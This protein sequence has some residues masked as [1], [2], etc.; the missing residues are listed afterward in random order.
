MAAAIA[1]ATIA[2]AGI[3]EA[4]DIGAVDTIEAVA[5]VPIQ[6]AVHEA[7]AAVGLA[8]EAVV[9]AEADAGSCFHA[10]VVD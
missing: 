1:V 9:L 5:A 4:V 6:A 2:A 7:S 3:I 8:V 10:K